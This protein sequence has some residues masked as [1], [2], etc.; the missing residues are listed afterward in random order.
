MEDQ[1]SLLGF[2]CCPVWSTIDPL[3]YV[4]RLKRPRI[5]RPTF[6]AAAVCSRRLFFEQASG[7]GPCRRFQLWLSI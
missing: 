2:S 4:G 3:C 1:R 6:S 5:P 7:H